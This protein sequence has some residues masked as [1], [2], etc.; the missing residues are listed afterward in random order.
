MI[1]GSRNA[2]IVPHG[3]HLHIEP[4]AI[5]FDDIEANMK[6]PPKP[7]CSLTLQKLS[8]WFNPPL[9][10]PRYIQ[11]LVVRNLS[12]YAKR[13][14][15][16]VPKSAE[17][18]VVTEN[19]IGIAPGLSVSIDVEF[20]TRKPYDYVDKLVI[21]AE[22]FRYE[23]ELC[24]KAPCAAITF[25]TVV[26]FGAIAGATKAREQRRA[27]EAR[28]DFISPSRALKPNPPSG[29]I[30]PA[31]SSEDVKRVKL[32]LTQE[33]T[34]GTVHELVQLN[35]HGLSSLV[36]ANRTVDVHA[37]CVDQTLQ[38]YKD[39]QAHEGDGVDLG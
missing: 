2:T 16:E 29:K 1:K 18:R 32:E 4:T 14:R 31:G 23:V 8:T 30:G 35:L 17:F 12:T 21:T 22:D 33:P 27:L 7:C 24:A 26:D 15:C 5:T 11:T 25:D 38:V 20:L 13:I 39:G 34:P 19:E 9:N 28:F 6:S 10:P 37:Q 36:P 3:K